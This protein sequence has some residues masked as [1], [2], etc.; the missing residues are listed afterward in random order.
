MTVAEQIFRAYDIR[1]IVETDLTPATV[2]LIG[3]A[4]GTHA[5]QKNCTR[6]VIG[7]DGRLSSPELARELAAGLQAAGCDVIDIG[8]VA[9]PV[10]YFATHHL[11]TGTGIMITGSHNP[12]EYNG[13]KMMLGGNTL[14]GEQITALYHTIQNKTFTNGSGQSHAQSVTDAY[15]ARIVQDAR[16]KRPL[17]FAIDCGNGATGE[18][19]PALFKALGQKPVE[20]FCDIDGT[21]PNHH[22][23]P[24]KEKNLQDLRATVAEQNLELGLA[25]DGDGDRLGVVDSNGTIIWPDRQMILFARDILARQPNSRIIYD[26]KCSKHLKDAIQASGGEAIMSRTGHSLIKAKMQETNAALAGEMSGHIFFKE[27]WFGFDDG[28]YTAVRLLEI[29]SQSTLSPAEIFAALPNSVNT[30]EINLNFAEGEH[31]RFIEKFQKTARFADAEMITI[32]G[33]R[34]EFVDGWGL[35]RASNTTPC[36]VL[37]FEAN[38]NASL[39]RIKNLFKAQIHAIDSSLPLDF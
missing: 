21:F 34:A 23:D 24:S 29:L 9:T 6:V 1:G 31:Y 19:A 33:V 20:L 27:R 15:I 3:H 13:L 14:H 4:F 26:V 17:R 7:R 10:L 35:V 2:R 25:F 8:L 37:R 11:E 12:P 30:P 18:I 32:D 28:M 36:L 39:E 16:I 5:Q 38:T 22:P